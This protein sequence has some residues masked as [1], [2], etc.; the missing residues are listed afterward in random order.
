MDIILKFIFNNKEYCVFKEDNVFKYGYILNN[1]IKTDL[2]TLDKDIIDLVIHKIKPS[3]N[4][5]FYSKITLNNTKYSIYIDPKTRL[6]SFKPE[7]NQKDLIILN[8]LYNNLSPLE[9]YYDYNYRIGK[10]KEFST[11]ATSI[12]RTIVTIML[13]TSINITTVLCAIS[14][15][16]FNENYLQTLENRIESHIT[17]NISKKLSNNPSN[18]EI[19]N[20]IRDALSQNPNIGQ[21]EKNIILE[22]LDIFYDNK[23]YIDFENVY[24]NLVNMKVEYISENVIEKEPNTAAIWIP[25]VQKIIIGNAKSIDDTNESIFTHEFC[26]AITKDKNGISFLQESINSECNSHYYKEDSGYNSIKPYMKALERIIGKEP[27]KKYFCVSDDEIIINELTEII[28]DRNK[29][30][31]FLETLEDYYRIKYKNHL[32]NHSTEELERDTSE[33][34][35]NY[36]NEYYT[37]KYNKSMSDDL[38]ISYYLEPDDLESKIRFALNFA[39]IKSINNLYSGKEIALSTSNTFS[40]VKPKVYARDISYQ[41]SGYDKDGNIVYTLIPSGY[42]YICILDDLEFNNKLYQ[43]HKN[44]Y[45]IKTFTTD[46]LDMKN[47]YRNALAKIL[48]VSKTLDWILNQNNDTII[49]ELTNIINDKNK[50][51]S[52]LKSIK[53]N[54]IEQ[55]VT[56]YEEYYRSKYNEDM[57]NDLYVLFIFNKTEFDNII[58]EKYN[59]NSDTRILT[60]F[61]SN[62]NNSDLEIYYI[63]DKI[64]TINDIRVYTIESIEYLG[65]LS[66]IKDLNINKGVVK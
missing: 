40:D 49:E 21:K 44:D 6:K 46:E 4:T 12:G 35:K 31:S 41:I 62:D 13:L 5:I 52:L 47:I 7:P 65:L 37:A 1:E 45:K 19:E 59:L 15:F 61:T 39:S 58:R 26:H 9:F 10:E 11:I 33:K 38:I 22:H 2:S 56:L 17:Y 18:S 27:L 66:N 25:I 42:E 34:I 54:N 20:L 28:N 60:K 48:P 50:A 14:E 8:S 63:N 29:A 16:K 24:Q 53:E 55:F 36:L 3:N 23:D 32:F 30:I 64:E 57:Y 51:E 43:Q